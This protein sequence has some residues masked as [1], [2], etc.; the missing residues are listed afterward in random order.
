MQKKKHPEALWILPLMRYLNF[1]KHK[2]EYSDI[3]IRLE[4]FR[5]RYLCEN[6]T[7]FL[8][9]MPL[10]GTGKILYVTQGHA[11]FCIRRFAKGHSGKYEWIL[12]P[13]T[14]SPN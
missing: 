5:S 12:T 9:E 13:S 1:A 7:I 2:E 14:Y 10:D 8:N 6:T 11:H 4:K 3:L